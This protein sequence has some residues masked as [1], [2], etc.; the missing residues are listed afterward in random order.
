M[1]LEACQNFAWPYSGIGQR[2]RKHPAEIGRL[3]RSR[4][5]LDDIA[6]IG[7]QVLPISAQ[8]VLSA[9]DSSRQFGLLSGDALA[10]AIMR[11]HPITDI[12]SNDS[13]FER[14]PGLTRYT[15]I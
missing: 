9:A 12:A 11:S 5:A 10:I 2:L 13:D 6:A 7:V 3:V 8:D 14:V 4:Q 15:P 1:T